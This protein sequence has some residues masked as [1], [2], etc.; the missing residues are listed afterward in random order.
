[1]VIPEDPPETYECLMCSCLNA[2]LDVAMKAL[3]DIM[4]EDYR[5]NRPASHTIAF[6]AM[7]KIAAEAL[8][9]FCSNC[10]GPDTDGGHYPGCT[11]GDRR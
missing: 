10:D 7:G 6:K 5:G 8:G 3:K 4:N 11:P 1:M 2:Q 9:E